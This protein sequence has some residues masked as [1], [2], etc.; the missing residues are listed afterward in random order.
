VRQHR[1]L[2]RREWPDSTTSVETVPVKPA[3]IN[4]GNQPV[5]AKIVPAAGHHDE[6]EPVAAAPPYPVAVAGDQHG[7]GGDPGKQRGEDGADGRVR[8]PAPGEDDADQYRAKAVGECS[9][10]LRGDDAARVG[11]QACS[12]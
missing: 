12:S 9:C 4:A 8:E 10:P 7:N 11:A 6:Q 5:S 2:E 1:L 3:R